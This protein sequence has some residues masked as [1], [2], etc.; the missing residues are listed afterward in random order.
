MYLESAAAARS[1]LADPAA[2]H[3]WHD[4]SALAQMTIGDL[5]GHLMRSATNVVRYMSEP[6]GPDVGPLLDAPGYL[7]SIDGLS[8]PDGPDR[9]S[10][11]HRVIRHRAA[12]D[13]ADGSEAVLGRW[14]GAV[15]E[16]S[17]SL[18]A[19]PA[20]R[21]V[22]VIDGRRMLIDDYL[23]TR[24]VE[25]LIHSDDLAVSLDVPLPDFSPTAWHAVL[26]CLTEVAVRRHGPLAVVRAM[27]RTERDQVRALRVL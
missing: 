18:S 8:G 17:R 13:A 23:A 27:T 21:I 19:E 4:Q 9:Y 10:E 14:D 3:R 5:C 20:T 2:G 26:E 16:L 6:D 11:L 7:L 24:L 15:E 12:V 1:L 25:M 22:T